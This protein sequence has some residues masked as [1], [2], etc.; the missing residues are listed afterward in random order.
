MVLGNRSRQKS[1]KMGWQDDVGTAVLATLKF[2]KDNLATQ[3]SILSD[4]TP[5]AGADIGLIK[6]QTD[7]LPH[8]L[9][10]QPSVPVNITAIL[11]GETDFLNL[12]T[13]S[14]HYAVRGL[15]LKCADPGANIIIVRLYE[16]IN[17][18]LTNVDSY[19]ITGSLDPV[20]STFGTYFS[21]TTMFGKTNIFGDNIKITV[22][23]SAGG[24]YAVT[25][26][27]DYEDAT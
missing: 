11:A 8:V 12:S 18:V 1:D 27:Y 17:N 3:L 21:M 4:A 16:L 5:F 6:I 25:G 24:P 14:H 23:A 13:A 7:T 26:Q 22:Q 20:E 9:K 2:I 15:R 19:P 10:D